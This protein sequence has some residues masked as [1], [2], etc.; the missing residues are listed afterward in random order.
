MNT[1]PDAA[2]RA[3]AKHTRLRNESDSEIAR[4]WIAIHISPQLYNCIATD[5]PLMKLRTHKPA[6]EHYYTE[7]KLDPAAFVHVMQQ[8]HAPYDAIKMHDSALELPSLHR[9]VDT[10]HGVSEEAW[11][12]FERKDMWKDRAYYV[13]M[14]RET[15]LYPL[16]NAIY[17]ADVA[18]AEKNDMRHKDAVSDMYHRLLLYKDQHGA[19]AVSNT[20][21]INVIGMIQLVPVEN[22]GVNCGEM[23]TEYEEEKRRLAEAEELNEALPQQQ[24]QDVGAAKIRINI[25]P[26][27]PPTG[28][29]DFEHLRQHADVQA[30]RKS[31]NLSATFDTPKLAKQMVL[32]RA[33]VKTADTIHGRMQ[34]ALGK[35]D[36]SWE[37]VE[38]ALQ[39]FDWTRVQFPLDDPS[40]VDTHRVACLLEHTYAPTALQLVKTHFRLFDTSAIADVDAS[41]SNALIQQHVQR[42]LKKYAQPSQVFINTILSL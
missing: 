36:A 9:F 22:H 32:A 1:A 31:A 39:H 15:D 3:F 42:F 6:L 4:R 20:D 34:R 14:T 28:K 37:T 23:K 35:S 19:D 33:G 27:A 25:A 38:H 2:L 40:V 21:L 7:A 10:L 8:G 29:L 5:L 11:Q 18:D 41:S 30:Y 16:V 17:M 24:Q 13:A 12:P 26:A